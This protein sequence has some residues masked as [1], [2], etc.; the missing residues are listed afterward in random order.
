MENPLLVDGPGVGGL[1]HGLPCGELLV[2]N[3][4]ANHT[5]LT[6]RRRT[7][8]LGSLEN[9]LG[10]VVCRAAVKD[11][12]VGQH[13]PTQ[14]CLKSDVVVDLHDATHRNAERW[15]GKGVKN[16]RERRRLH[17][18]QSQSVL[19]ERHLWRA[20]P[21]LRLLPEMVEAEEFR[22][23]RHSEDEVV[24]HQEAGDDVDVRR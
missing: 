18:V 14:D 19:V 7:R 15:R 12:D 3:G 5:D 16:E 11:P 21:G 22:L 8:E 17:V 6:V 2:V 23:V 10:A 13:H 20:E 4:D 9:D 24:G 1:R